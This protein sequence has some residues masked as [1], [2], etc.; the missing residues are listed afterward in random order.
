M[1][2]SKSVLVPQ[3]TCANFLPGRVVCV[4]PHPSSMKGSYMRQEDPWVVQQ[5]RRDRGSYR[6]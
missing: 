6:T 3:V 5:A 2:A 1:E 4:P